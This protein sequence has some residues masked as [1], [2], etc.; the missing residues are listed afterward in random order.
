MAPPNELNDVKVT[1]MM[2]KATRERKST[3]TLRAVSA[4]LLTFLVVE[5]RAHEVAFEQR[6]QQ[7]VRLIILR[8][9]NLNSSLF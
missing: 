3:L 1:K 7:A 6:E 2:P 5:I 4:A 8:F 9:V